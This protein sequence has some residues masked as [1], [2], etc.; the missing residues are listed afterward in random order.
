M[1]LP[2]KSDPHLRPP[3][4]SKGDAL[5]APVFEGGLLL[6][7][8]AIGL[9]AGRPLLFASLGPTAY[10]Q[11]EKPDIPSAKPYNVFVGHMIGLGCGFLALYATRAFAAPNVLT[12]HQLTAPRLWA[13]II[14]VVLTT[15]VSIL[16]RASQPAAAAT[17]LLVALGQF[18]TW[19]EAQVV[20][21]AVAILT[22]VGEPVRR[23]R[24]RQ[25]LQSRAEQRD[26][27]AA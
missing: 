10:E 23:F 27:L 11:T 15:V 16:L 22:V 25:R 5:W 1:P 19:H 12:T 8:G 9:A 24:L 3:S 14:A 7:C 21:I 26:K 13:G 4:L 6:L 2:Q 20:I 18:Q 17:S